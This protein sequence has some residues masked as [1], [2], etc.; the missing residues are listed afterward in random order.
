MSTD[1][2]LD[3]LIRYGF[4]VL[5]AFAILAVGAIAARWIGGLADHGL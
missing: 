2:I 5:G 3:L 1:L 4:Q